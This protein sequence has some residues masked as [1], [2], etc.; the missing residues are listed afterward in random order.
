[1][2]D[3]ENRTTSELLAL[4]LTSSDDDDG[5]A[6]G[7]KAISELHR[8]GTD[9]IFE[10]CQSLCGGV[11]PQERRVGADILGQLGWNKGYPFR[12]VTLPILFQLV[13]T[14]QDIDILHSACVA[15]GHLNDERAIEP[16]LTL[17]AHPSV[18]VRHSVVFGLLALED[19]RAVKAL[20][21]LSND[22]DEL[23]RDWATFG[24]GSQI[25][26]D[27]EEIRQA[28][29]ERLDDPDEVTRGEAMVGLAERRDEKLITALLAELKYVPNWDYP[30]AAARILGDARLLPALQRLEADWTGD[31]DGKYRALEEAIAACKNPKSDE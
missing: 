5:D 19:E 2:A 17:K 15:L 29:V 1:M 12:D 28:L 26:L 14:D 7:W 8:R 23:V 20:I 18:I 24:L 16:L 13:Y 11:N 6:E 27:T 31:K 30:F 25:D 10:A 22:S 3:L 21:E 9:D 4:A